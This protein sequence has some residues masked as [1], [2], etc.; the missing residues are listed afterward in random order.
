ML[1]LAAVAGVIVAAIS[2]GGV[3]LIIGYWV[4][5]LGFCILLLLVAIDYGVKM[6]KGNHEDQNLEPDTIGS[7]ITNSNTGSVSRHANPQAVTA[8]RPQPGAKRKAKRRRF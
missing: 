6:G 4:I 7:S 3:W 2:L 8:P 5:T 1:S